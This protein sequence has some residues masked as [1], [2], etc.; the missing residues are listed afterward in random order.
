M[1]KKIVIAIE[2]TGLEP[3]WD[4]ILRVVIADFSGKILFDRYFKPRVDSWD[5][6]MAVN[7]IM[8]EMVRNAPEI[9][10]FLPEIQDIIDDVERII[11][12]NADFVLEFLQSAGISVGAEVVD[13]MS[14]FADR[15]NDGYFMKL[16]ECAN[17]CEYSYEKPAYDTAEK[18][19]AILHCYKF[20]MR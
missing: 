12:Y 2:T 10:D 14:G 11:F 6:A 9:W 3:E 8:P 7:H 16:T 15:Y 13:V 18:C 20:I 4:E 5:E 17:F 1:D 19:C